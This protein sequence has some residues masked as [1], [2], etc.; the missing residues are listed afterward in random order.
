MPEL[1]ISNCKVCCSDEQKLDSARQFSRLH[2][3]PM[4]KPGEHSLL[5][6]F[7]AEGV[8][9]REGK[10]RLRVD[11][12]GGETAHRKK[13]GG[14]RGQAL[15]RAVGIKPG[16]LLPTIIDAT[17]GLARDA[18]V[19]ASL[20][21]SVQMI[22]QSPVVAMLVEDAILRAEDD[23]LFQQIRKI[24]FSLVQGNSIEILVAMTADNPPDT[25]YLDPMFPQRR[26]SAAVKKNMQV[27]Q[28]LLGHHQDTNIGL[29]NAALDCA[30]KR[31]VVKRPKGAPCLT[32]LKPTAEIKT[33]KT[34]YDLYVVC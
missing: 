10:V 3:I 27:L 14:G 16:K 4:C 29:L 1:P 20:G 18:F 2:K 32:E 21:C 15:A 23:P 30:V 17:A 34:R 11:F 12:L 22:E 5:L 19:L 8:V 13:Y 24:G 26:K 6:D 28:Q 31:V 33:R 9:L 25:V 7:S